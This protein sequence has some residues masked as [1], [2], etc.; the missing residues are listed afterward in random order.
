MNWIWTM[1]ILPEQLSFG[2]RRLITVQPESNPLTAT[3]TEL[4]AYL[5][6]AEQGRDASRVNWL[7]VGTDDK[8]RE[9]H[10]FGIYKSN[11]GVCDG[12]RYA[13]NLLK[14]VRS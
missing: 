9:A 11:E 3:I 14:G 5:E 12:I 4:T 2:P 13:I 10:L 8:H 1:A 7:Q 6:H